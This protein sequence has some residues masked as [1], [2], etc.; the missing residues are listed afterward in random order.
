[1]V[2]VAIKQEGFC[3]SIGFRNS[4]DKSLRLS[5]VAGVRIFVCD[6]LAFRGQF[7]PMIAKH[8]KHFELR[9]GVALGVDKIH[10]Q[11]DPFAKQI[12]GWQ[13][14]PVS[15]L[16]AKAFFYDAFLIEEKFSP[17]IMPVVHQFYFGEKH[18]QKGNAWALHNA[19]TSAFGTLDPIKQFELTAK[20]GDFFPQIWN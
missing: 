2:E 17:K 3:F 6:N 12:E 15:D 10:R 4:N 11:F 14:T 7:M 8:T 5:M 16:D 1:V 20:L 13:N 19:M 9:D 18:M